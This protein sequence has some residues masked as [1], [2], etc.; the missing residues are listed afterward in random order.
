MVTIEMNPG[1]D[2]GDIS[3]EEASFLKDLDAVMKKHD[4]GLC[5]SFDEDEMECA[6]NP[7]E[8]VNA[9]TVQFESNACEKGKAKAIS[10][11]W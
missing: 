7:Q 5:Y 11:G 8:M 10:V 1:L 4:V 9:I 2:D 6:E 3:I